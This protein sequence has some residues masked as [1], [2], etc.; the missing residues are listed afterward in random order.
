MIEFAHE[1]FKCGSGSYDHGSEWWT[2]I[3]YAFSVNYNFSV[4]ATNRCYHLR[5]DYCKTRISSFVLRCNLDFL[6]IR[7]TTNG[8]CKVQLFMGS[9]RRRYLDI[10]GILSYY[11][12]MKKLYY[13]LTID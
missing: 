3:R 11:N 13:Y 12:I 8:L 2:F 5:L 6:P 4:L 1:L 9:L 10:K 7:N